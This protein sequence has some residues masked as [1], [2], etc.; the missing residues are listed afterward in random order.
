MHG[1]RLHI[2]SFDVPYPANYGGAIDVYYKIKALAE[3]GAEIVLHCFAYGRAEA[4]ILHQWCKEIYYYKRVTGFGGLSLSEPYIMYSRRSKEL[5]SNLLKDNAPILFEGIHTCHYVNDP[6]LGNRIKLVRNHN[7]EYQYY[8]EL[9]RRTGSLL[10]RLFFWNESRLLQRAE[11]NLHGCQALLPISQTDTAFFQNIYRDKTV[12]HIPGFHPFDEVI[13]KPGS[14][15]FCLYHGNLGH[16]ENIEAALF[17]I[18]EVFSKLTLPLTIAGRSPHASILQA[19]KAHP[20]ILVVA[21]PAE[22]AMNQLMQE[23][24][25]HVL[26]TF[27][28]TGMKLKLLNALFSGRHVLVNEPMIQ[29]TTLGALCRV[30][31]ANP[32]QMAA[33]I[34]SLMKIPF[35]ADDL[36]TRRALL[37]EHYSNSA[38]AA[39]IIGLLEKK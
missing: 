33:T 17:L 24:H 35:T 7:V 18:R 4:T 38:H 5:L 9:S 28:P 29:G 13:S 25:I 21:D 12:V 39:R 36:R 16:P 3:A 26:P 6:A 19:A 22:T 32:A 14:G 11:R 20:N 37:T 23:A 2:V 10:Q 8:R 34:D 30:V 31:D 15:M 27:Q 1:A